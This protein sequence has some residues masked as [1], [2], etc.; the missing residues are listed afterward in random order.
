MSQS[1]YED[2]A[3]RILHREA[4]CLDERR[5]DE[6][7]ALFSPDCEY[8]VPTW[9]SEAALSEDPQRELSHVYYASRAGLEDR[10]VRIRTGRSPA[11]TP[12]RRTAHLVTNIEVLEADPTAM[13][14]RSTWANH[15]FDPHHRQQGV[16]FGW[17]SY[18]LEYGTA[19]WLIARKKVVLQ[20]DQLP[21][22]IDIYCL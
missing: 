6:W 5:W 2:I 14:V 8:W 13:S 4:A 10:I 9:R 20:N 1:S 12:M 3:R 22:M 11:S 7:I 15:V 18:R 16:L 17:S 21:A 19:G